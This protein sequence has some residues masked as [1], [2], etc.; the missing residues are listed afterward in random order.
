MIVFQRIANRQNQPKQIPNANIFDQKYSPSLVPTYLSLSLRDGNLGI[1]KSVVFYPCSN[2]RRA[3]L[4]LIAI[5]RFCWLKL[6]ATCIVNKVTM[7]LKN[8]ILFPGI[9]SIA[10]PVPYFA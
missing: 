3:L 2:K 8:G 6:R 1:E 7:Q 5:V 9:D 4:L 10:K